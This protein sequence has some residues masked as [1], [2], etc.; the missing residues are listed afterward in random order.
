MKKGAHGA[1]RCRRGGAVWAGRVRRVGRRLT[2]LEVEEKGEHCSG[3]DGSG[4]E[5]LYSTLR[6]VRENL[7]LLDAHF[8]PDS[9]GLPHPLYSPWCAHWSKQSCVREWQSRLEGARAARRV[10]AEPCGSTAGATETAT[11]RTRGARPRPAAAGVSRRPAAA[12]RTCAPQRKLA[13][14]NSGH[15]GR[16]PRVASHAGPP[17]AA[18]LA[19]RRGRRVHVGAGRGAPEPELLEGRLRELEQ[20]GADADAPVGAAVFQ[21]RL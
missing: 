17:D 14:T 4:R 6:G 8:G 21:A 18:R 1:H 11:L 3:G 12:N 5:G 16:E 2:V 13:R 7:P 19:A 20:R 9:L 10:R 15:N